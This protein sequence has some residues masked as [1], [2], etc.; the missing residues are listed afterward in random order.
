[1]AGGTRR[2]IHLWTLA[3]RARHAIEGNGVRRARV[4]PREHA[5]HTVLHRVIATHLDTFLRAAAEAGEETGLPQFVE[6]EF[7][8]F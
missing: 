3:R 7:P 4:W 2:L 8:D 1:M 5:E 6:R